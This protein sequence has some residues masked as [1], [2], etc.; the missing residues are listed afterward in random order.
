MVLYGHAT[1]GSKES[2][3]QL[4]G[5]VNGVSM[6]GV[7]LVRAVTPVAGGLMWDWSV[8]LDFGLHSF[9]PFV[10]MAGISVG[11]GLISTMPRELAT[12]YPDVEGTNDNHSVA[13]GH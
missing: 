9:V 11:L 7:A 13:A 10:I 6:S 8:S 1:N 5:L 4:Q 12:P 3:L 2:C